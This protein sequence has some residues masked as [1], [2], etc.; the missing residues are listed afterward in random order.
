MAT[1]APFDCNRRWRSLWAPRHYAAVFIPLTE[2]RPA[3]T[4]SG[5]AAQPRKT[6]MP[7]R[8]RQLIGAIAVALT[9]LAVAA[10]ALAKDPAQARAERRKMCDEALAT[11]YKS[12]PEVKAEI[13]K[14]AGY[15]CF[16]SFGISF[17][18][19]G[20]GGAGLVHD[21]KTRKDVYMNMGQATG[22]VEFG[23]KDYREVLVFKDAKTMQEFVNNGWQFGGTVQAGAAAEGKGA[24]A[25][26]SE[27]STGQISVYPM[28]KTS[29]AVG[30]AIG[31]RKY[32]KD[33]DLN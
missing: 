18:F 11:L 1:L 22:G 27:D 8:P 6:M 33:S 23:I 12:K 4:R 19:G 5:P 14:A 20:A 24:Q 2:Y 21:N 25:A 10:P 7:N 16:S 26:K 15:G 28:T 3:T 31:P 13:A 32:W 17:F 9:A 29:L 30:V